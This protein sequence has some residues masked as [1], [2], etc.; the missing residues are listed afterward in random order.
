MRLLLIAL[1]IALL[2]GCSTT[3]K[4]ADA[5]DETEQLLIAASQKVVGDFSSELKQELLG[6]LNEGGPANAIAVC[7]T[8]APLIAA[9]HSESEFLSINRIT[10]R[11][12]NPKN[13]ADSTQMEVLTKMSL[14]STINE[15]H[16]WA[17]TET[18]RKFSYY[19]AIRVNALCL[20]C[21]G[22]TEDIDPSVREELV[23]SYPGDRAVEY[24]VG[25]FRGAFLVEI[26]WPQGE[27]IVQQLT[28]TEN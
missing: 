13:L 9:A 28:T 21:H 25:D 18:G 12:R 1:T 23:N 11:N 27:E 10:D 2:M 5:V 14:D 4:K 17:D 3:E 7:E 8:K 26:D 6:A 19:K 20:K 16:F 22:K 15:Q 24:E